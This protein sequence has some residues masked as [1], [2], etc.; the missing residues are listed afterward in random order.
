MF[1]EDSLERSEAQAMQ[2]RGYDGEPASPEQVAVRGTSS[3]GCRGSTCGSS[4]WTAGDVL[5]CLHMMRR[6][7]DKTFASAGP[8]PLWQRF[9][10]RAGVRFSL[11]TTAILRWPPHRQREA[12]ILREFELDQ[13][14][15]SKGRPVE[16]PPQAPQLHPNLK[17][18]ILQPRKKREEGFMGR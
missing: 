14:D 12:E 2:Q 8:P 7:R 18:Q 6:R 16:R 5:R 15:D 10:W 3:C 9:P 11:L 17:E 13:D 1:G 4:V